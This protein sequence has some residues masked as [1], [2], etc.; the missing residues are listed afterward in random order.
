MG[1]PPTSPD[2]LASPAGPGT[3]QPS[4]STAVPEAAVPPKEASENHGGE[5]GEP[6]AFDPG[7]GAT[8]FDPADAGETREVRIS[9][10][11]A[12]L[13]VFYIVAYLTL[14]A[15][16]MLFT[17]FALELRLAEQFGSV[18]LGP[19]LAVLAGASGY[20]FGSRGD[21]ET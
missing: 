10:E 12:A 17:L 21:G 18:V 19:L 8:T 4:S 2:P 16:L 13:R 14:F 20:Y 11:Q 7:G 15:I 5:S 6:G 1:A 9:R 3:P